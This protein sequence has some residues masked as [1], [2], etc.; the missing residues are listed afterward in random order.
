[1]VM[2]TDPIYQL[3]LTI[4][5]EKTL[6]PSTLT[7]LKDIHEL[8]TPC[9]IQSRTRGIKW[10]S[11]SLGAPPLFSPGVHS[12]PEPPRPLPIDRVFW[13]GTDECLPGRHSRFLWD[14]VCLPVPV[15]PSGLILG[16]CV[17]LSRFH[18]ALLSH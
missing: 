16:D 4:M 17:F 5:H 9:S 7:T 11:K 1:M 10:D 18:D 2:V 12:S 8:W 14:R 13:E 6:R 15:F 3:H